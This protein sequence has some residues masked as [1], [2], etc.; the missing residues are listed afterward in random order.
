MIAGSELPASRVVSAESK[1]SAARSAVGARSSVGPPK[2]SSRKYTLGESSESVKKRGGKM[3][4]MA[5]VN[6]KQQ[7][8]H[9][10]NHAIYTFA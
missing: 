8:R 2:K 6:V 5:K 1:K 3:H 10:K 9:R 4:Q 7:S